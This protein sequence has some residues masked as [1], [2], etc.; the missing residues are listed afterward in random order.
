MRKAVQLSKIGDAAV[1]FTSSWYYPGVFLRSVATFPSE[2]LLM[3]VANQ[4]SQGGSTLQCSSL[5][6]SS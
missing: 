5:T 2:N 1:G 6:F 4:L 3:R